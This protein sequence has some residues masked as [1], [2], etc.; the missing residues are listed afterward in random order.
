MAYMP[1]TAPSLGASCAEVVKAVSEVRGLKAGRIADVAAA[2]NLDWA[3]VRGLSFR[4]LSGGMKQKLLLAMTLTSGASLFILDEPTASLDPGAREAFFN[5][6]KA[7]D[8]RA[9]LL[10]CSHRLEELR[11][12]VDQALVLQE[13]RLAYQGPAAP[14]LIPPD[15]TGQE[16]PGRLQIQWGRIRRP[17]DAA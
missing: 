1:Q 5:L 6:F 3:M 7:L 16:D 4:A 11:V 10:L 17:A 13:G 8:G 2:L 14:L 9:T 12:L 15:E